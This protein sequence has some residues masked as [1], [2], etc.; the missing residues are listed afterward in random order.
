MLTTV[1]FRA[2]QSWKNTLDLLGRISNYLT[3][4]K[5]QLEHFVPHPTLRTV[6]DL[7]NAR[8]NL[9]KRCCSSLTKQ[10]FS[11]FNRI[12]YCY[13]CNQEPIKSKLILISIS[14]TCRINN[15]FCFDRPVW[16][17]HIPSSIRSEIESSDWCRHVYLGPIHPRSNCKGLGQGIWVNVAILWKRDLWKVN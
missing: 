5:W 12:C 1:L 8:S 6:W 4:I 7:Q 2:T 15:L 17:E 3:Q 11:W 13:S 9:D 14:V 16:G 10:I